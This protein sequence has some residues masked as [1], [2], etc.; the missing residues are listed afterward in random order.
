MQKQ[1]QAQIERIKARGATYVDSRW[2]PFE[3]ANFL[4][5]LNGNLKTTS[6]SGKVVSAS[7]CC[8]RAPGVFRHL[9]M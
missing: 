3:E 4:M 2:Y 7:V 6:M 9:R 5:M 8:T 1:I